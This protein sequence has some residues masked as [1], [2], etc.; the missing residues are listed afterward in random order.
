MHTY[1]FSYMYTS[2]GMVMEYILALACIN[3]IYFLA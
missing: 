2:L 1:I 3:E